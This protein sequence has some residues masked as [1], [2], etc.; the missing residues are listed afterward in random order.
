MACGNGTRR[1]V[2][3][4]SENRRLLECDRGQPLRAGRPAPVREGLLVEMTDTAALQENLLRALIDCVPDYLFIKDIESRFVVANPPVG[5][6]LGIPSRD[7]IGKTDFD[8]HPREL[9]A[10]FFSDEQEVISSGIPKIDIVEFVV[11]PSGQKKWLAASKLPLRDPQGKISGVVGVCRD[12][13]ERR[14]AEEALIASEAQLLNALKIARA[15]HWV[16]DVDLDQFTFNDNFYAVFRKTAHEV[17]GY[18]MRSADYAVRFCHPED[19]PLVGSVIAN[20]IAGSDPDYSA[21]LEHRVVFGD[22]QT[23]WVAMRL[24]IAKDDTGRT[25]RCYGVNRDITGRKQNEIALAEAESRWN[26]ALEGAGQGVWDHNLKCGTAYFSP[27]WRQMRGIGPD[28]PVDA[29]REAWLSRVHPDDHKR[30]RQETEQQNS[31][32][33]TQ[34]SFEYRERHRD[35]HYIWILSRGKPV[36]W[37]ADGRVARIIGTDTD[38][39]SIKQ[40]EAKAA[41]E[42]EQTYRKHLAALK[43]AQ[44]ATEAAHKLAE[45]MARHDALTGLPNRRVFTEVLEELL[46]RARRR[47]SRPLQARQ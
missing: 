10:K 13:T 20:A 5:D 40:A 35:G 25:V 29:S 7:L 36:E 21:E 9:A 33:L 44:E 4:A 26:F 6:D 16:Y 18:A 45:L 24:F 14:R 39:T 38:I 32:T 46:A 11:T 1:D 17:G 41:E 19:A 47:R 30:L 42:K 15:G 37:L 8:L 43:K 12:I 27:M 34:N 3:Q 31:G 28:E 22:G 23:G 2:N